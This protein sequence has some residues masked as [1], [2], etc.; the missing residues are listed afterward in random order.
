MFNWPS[1]SDIRGCCIEATRAV[2]ACAMDIT[3]YTIVTNDNE[4]LV[5]AQA[6]IHKATQKDIAN[7]GV[8]L[9]SIDY[10]LY[11]RYQR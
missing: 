9:C 6:H 7:D 11:Y 8:A 3:F 10:L 4:Q 2:C 5:A 1:S